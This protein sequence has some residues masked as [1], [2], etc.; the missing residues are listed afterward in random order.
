M[1]VI[2]LFRNTSRLSL[3]HCLETFKYVEVPIISMG[4]ITL[5]RL[6][7]ELLSIKEELK[8][9]SLVLEE[10]FE[11][12]DEAKKELERSRKEPLTSYVDHEEVLKEFS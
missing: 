12:S 7:K 1:N 5:E 3:H 8:R 2:K 4:S 9:I 6:H 10:D 11:L